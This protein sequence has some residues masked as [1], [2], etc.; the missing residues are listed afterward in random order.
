MGH[1]NKPD[2]GWWRTCLIQMK[3]IGNAKNLI[4]ET[5][6]PV[7]IFFIAGC[8]YMIL[9]SIFIGSLSFMERRLG[10]RHDTYVMDGQ[11]ESCSGEN[12]RWIKILSRNRPSPSILILIYCIV[13][14][15]YCTPSGAVSKPDTLSA[16]SGEASLTNFI[17]EKFHCAFHDALVVLTFQLCDKQRIF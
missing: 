7:E 14:L 10:C 9:S 12:C 6:M 13:W 5:F 3:G 16:C 15:K 4:A 17:F 2:G 11:L 8:I 1:R